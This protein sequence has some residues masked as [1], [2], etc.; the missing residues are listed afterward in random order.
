MDKV[1]IEILNDGTIKTSTDR[2][3]AP[4]HS[5]AEGFLS[6][7]AKLTGG[8]VDRQRKGSGHHTHTHEHG[9]THQH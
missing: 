4:N 3:S 2:I 7:M 9:E 1:K 6:N 8:K 5:N